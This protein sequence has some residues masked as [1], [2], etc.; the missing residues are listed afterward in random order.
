MKKRIG[1]KDW[2]EQ[3]RRGC[4]ALDYQVYRKMVADEETTWEE[5]ERAKMSKPCV[6]VNRKAK[7]RA[8]LEKF[9]AKAA[10]A[11]DEAAE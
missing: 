1:R 10:K 4:S 9:R 8:Q 5:L 2:K 7:A 11:Q 6:R 3:V